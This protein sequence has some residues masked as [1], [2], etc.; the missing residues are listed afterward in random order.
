MLFVLN[1]FKNKEL[2]SKRTLNESKGIEKY[3]L[4][5]KTFTWDP[6]AKVPPTVAKYF[7]ACFA[8]TVLPAPD[9][10]D[11]MIDWSK[12]FLQKNEIFNKKITIFK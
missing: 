11:T 5:Q 3:W 1:C 2:L 8:L 6:A 10:P 9:S 4:G 7:K 12:D